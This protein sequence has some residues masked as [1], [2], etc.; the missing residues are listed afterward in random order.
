MGFARLKLR[1]GS[2]S[3]CTRCM[4]LLV[5]FVPLHASA[6][7]T[8]SA[9]ATMALSNS[10]RVKLAMDDLRRARA[11]VSET[12][13]VYIPSV[14][15]NGGAG[16]SYG[17]TLN[18]PTIL[19]VNSQSLVYSSAQRFYLRASR[20]SLQAAMLTLQ[21]GQEQVEEDTVLTYVSLENIQQT[22][23]A[24]S[25]EYEDCNKLQI[26]V[27]KRFDAGVE[28]ELEVNLARRQVL[29]IRLQQ[30]QLE[31]EAILLRQHLSALTGLPASGIVT[32]PE[33]IPAIDP[34]NPEE[35]TMPTSSAEQAVAV[36]AE[37]REQHAKGDASY[38]WKPQVG[39]AAQYGRVSPI[40]D[41]SEYYNLHGKY[42]VG[43]IG[44][45][46][47]FPVFDA[48]H[49]AR[50]DQANADAA[51]ARHDLE[52]TTLQRQEDRL[53]L[54]H[55]LAELTVRTQMAE[56]DL[57]IAEAQLKAT[58]IETAKGGDGATVLTPK[59]EQNARIR[60]RQRYL[61]V[62][63]ARFQMK[64]A[65]ISMLRMAGGLEAWL[66]LRIHR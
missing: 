58:T 27:Q 28:T 20:L 32:M 66:R 25:A 33:S 65:Q 18:V 54:I 30:L 10:P 26:I 29:G 2:V 38:R 49:R 50:S 9:A 57:S 62:L 35:I 46:V 64:K 5:G 31:D 11:V 15:A 3:V 44:V 39:F 1:I 22:K 63:D 21:D 34:V 17:I 59:D 36:N 23:A 40:N 4:L 52:V 60:S 41:V 16:D 47:Q 53:R 7:I 6:Q 13:D 61:D 12:K 37:A 19:T 24:L 43:F 14:V 45:Q 51:H 48:A 55:S 8:L 42:N 56:L